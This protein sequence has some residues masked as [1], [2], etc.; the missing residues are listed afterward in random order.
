MNI[1]PTA[2][3]L[4]VIII[5]LVSERL[6][7]IMVLYQSSPWSPVHCPL[8]VIHHLLY[9][10]FE[11]GNS[12]ETGWIVLKFGPHIGSNSVPSRDCRDMV[13]IELKMI[14]KTVHSYAQYFIGHLFLWNLWLFMM[15]A[16][17]KF[18]WCWKNL[19]MPTYFQLH[20]IETFISGK[21]YFDVVV[22]M[23][24][25]YILQNNHRWLY[26][27]RVTGF[28]AGTLHWRQNERD[29]VSNHQ[30]LDCL[31]SCLFKRRSKKK[32]KASHHWPLWEEFT[33][34]WWIPLTKGQ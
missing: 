1:L 11:C 14:E 13:V 12:K 16:Q 8:S 9:K 2:Q 30:R 6:G 4:K 23:G 33:G 31:L 18:S 7:Y 3:H 15:F 24:C 21:H 26:V 22:K 10:W 34:D 28:C 20:Y 19:L 29:G 32:I 5:S 27:G 25:E 17:Y